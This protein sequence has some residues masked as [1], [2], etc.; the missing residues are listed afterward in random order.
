M[1]Q[2]LGCLRYFDSTPFIRIFLKKFFFHRECLS[3]RQKRLCDHP[4]LDNVGNS[5]TQRPTQRFTFPF[6]TLLCDPI[7]ITETKL[8]LRDLWK[9]ENENEI[10]IQG[11]KVHLYLYKNCFFDK[12]LLLYRNVLFPFPTPTFVKTED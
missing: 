9:N 11:L 6:P 12:L 7:K 10:T 5:V 4:K 8:V 3:L 2:M 1:Y